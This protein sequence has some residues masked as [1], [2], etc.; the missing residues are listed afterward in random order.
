MQENYNQGP[1]FGV[2]AEGE[3]A[4]S[5]MDL[6]LFALTNSQ[7]VCTVLFPGT[8]PSMYSSFQ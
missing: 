4:T 2:K 5:M 3:N 1:F 7:F 8:E 6:G